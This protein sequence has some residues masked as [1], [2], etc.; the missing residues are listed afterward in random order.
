MSLLKRACSFVENRNCEWGVPKPSQ[1]GLKL[2]RINEMGEL[3]ETS[4]NGSCGFAGHAG[5]PPTWSRK[6]WRML[7]EHVGVSQPRFWVGVL[8]STLRFLRDLCDHFASFAVKKLLTAKVAK[9][10]QERE[11]Q[12]CC[13]AAPYKEKQNQMFFLPG[14]G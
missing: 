14:V 1:A 7:S 13:V 6:V 10:R 11:D 3:P 12:P 4:R 2:P 9:N 5:K 8:I